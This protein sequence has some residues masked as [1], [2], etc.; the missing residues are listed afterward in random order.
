M[1]TASNQV[2]AAYGDPR[3]TRFTGPTNGAQSAQAN[4]PQGAVNRP[5][6]QISVNDQQN[7]NQT[8]MRERDSLDQDPNRETSESE[9]TPRIS[10]NQDTI[11]EDSNRDNLE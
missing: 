5:S 11:V 2:I 7:L 3:D 9:E 1:K 4:G 8:T 10:E 6:E